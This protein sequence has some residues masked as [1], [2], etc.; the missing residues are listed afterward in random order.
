MY[1]DMRTGAPKKG[2]DL[3]QKQLV[4]VTE[5][6]NMSVSD[7]METYSKS[8]RRIKSRCPILVENV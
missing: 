1:W 2:I 3:D 4:L 7:E 8:L 6:F 5:V